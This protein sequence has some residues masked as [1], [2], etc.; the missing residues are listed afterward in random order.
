M[1]AF[2]EQA[3]CVP[4]G[5]FDGGENIRRVPGT[6]PSDCPYDTGKTVR[7]SG[8]ARTWHLHML[9]G[10]DCSLM[11]TRS[12]GA[13]TGSPSHMRYTALMSRRI[14]QRELRNESGRIM[15]SLDKGEA[16]TVTRDGVPVGE[17]VPVRPR[18]F[19]PAEVVTA[20]Y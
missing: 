20:A 13:R 3:S 12:P 6:P 8:T 4:H 16:F 2:E 17:L 10:R 7:A 5:L 11:V 14:T 19:V 18:A 9:G 15:R 1:L